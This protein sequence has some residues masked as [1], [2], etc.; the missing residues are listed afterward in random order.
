MFEGLI[1]ST[2]D[3][4]NVKAFLRRKHFPSGKIKVSTFL[5]S[6]APARPFS[7]VLFY[8]YAYPRYR[9]PHVHF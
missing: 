5:V 9:L 2:L 4:V 8:V 1:L 6:T 7:N 3:Y